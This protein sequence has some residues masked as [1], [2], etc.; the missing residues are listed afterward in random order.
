M[1]QVTFLS[2]SL[3]LYLCTISLFCFYFFVFFSFRCNFCPFLSPFSFLCSLPLSQYSSLS[4]LSYINLSLQNLSSSHSSSVD[5]ATS[6]VAQK[7]LFLTTGSSEVG[8]NCLITLVL[9]E[10]PILMQLKLNC[11]KKTKSS[12][13]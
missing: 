11:T 13:H 5:V 3:D 2:F 8:L 1:K 10:S 12:L 6:S 9:G 4:P 7:K